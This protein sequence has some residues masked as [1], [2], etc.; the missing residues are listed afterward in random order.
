MSRSVASE[1][2]LRCY[3]ITLFG[4]SRLK[5]IKIIQL[6][7]IPSLRLSCRNMGARPESDFT[8]PK[9]DSRHHK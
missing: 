6:C 9:M 1:L 8:S 3:P 2:V 7:F 5:W 4:V